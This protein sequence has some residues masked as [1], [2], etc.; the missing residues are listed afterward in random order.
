MKYKTI[1]HVNAIDF[2]ELVNDF[3][4]NHDIKFTQFSTAV[5]NDGNVEL[6]LLIIYEDKVIPQKKKM[7]M[8]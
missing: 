6:T 4:E 8:V 1:R 2:D 7:V 3:A 5:L